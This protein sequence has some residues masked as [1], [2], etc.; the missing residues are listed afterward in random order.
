MAGTDFPITERQLQFHLEVAECDVRVMAQAGG[1]SLQVEHS[2]LAHTLHTQR[3]NPRVF[4]NLTTVAA[5]LKERGVKS[6][7]VMLEQIAAAPA[8]EIEAEFEK[9]FVESMN[10]AEP[11]RQRPSPRQIDPLS[12]DSDWDDVDALI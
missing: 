9:R 12:V 5:F 3:G 10:G 11:P 4:K 6:F 8:S 1:Y 2:D 7:S